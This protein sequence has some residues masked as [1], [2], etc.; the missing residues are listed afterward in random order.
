MKTGLSEFFHYNHWANM[1]LLDFLSGLTDARLDV[2]ID[3]VYGTLRETLHHML[4][5]EEG[6]AR[7]TWYRDTKQR[8][9]PTLKEMTEFPGFDVLK[10]RADQSG[11]ALIYAAENVDVHEG[12]MLDD[13]TY[14]AQ[15]I[16]VL[17]QAINHT[18]DH[19]SQIAT[20]LTQQGIDPPSLDAWSYNDATYLADE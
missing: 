7:H 3:G 6:Y 5:S 12:L 10:D 11:K 1:T 20:M 19:R 18:V 9:T 15:V 4:A 8:P 16:I 13:G 14:P 2:T 17:I